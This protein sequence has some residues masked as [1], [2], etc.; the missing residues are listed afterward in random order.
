MPERTSRI[1]PN[2][3]V[4]RTARA[5]VSSSHA[6]QIRA[7]SETESNESDMFSK[8]QLTRQARSAGAALLAG[9]TLSSGAFAAAPHAPLVMVAYSNRAG[10][11]ALVSGDYGS[12]AQ[13]MHRDVD[14]LSLPDPQALATNRCVAY[15]MTQQLAKARAACD[16]A[17]RATQR[18]DLSAPSWRAASVREKA[19]DAAVAYSNRAVLNWL[20]EDVSAAE[21]DLARARSLAPEASFV[22]RNSTAMQS[23]N[24]RPLPGATPAREAPQE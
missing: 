3:F 14:S 17:V 5:F 13:L 7:R 19:N 2:L 22:E 12:A 20:S 21:Q 23:K 10:G 6:L 8:D 1:A 18:A 11:A 9:A 24:S 16:E 15:A 4:C